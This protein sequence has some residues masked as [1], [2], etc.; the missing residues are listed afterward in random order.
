VFYFLKFL[1][2]GRLEFTDSSPQ[3]SKLA[4]IYQVETLKNVCQQL[5][6]VPDVEELTNC[7][8]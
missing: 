7:L 8:I 2:T 3:L 4:S 1:Y 6:R 5:N